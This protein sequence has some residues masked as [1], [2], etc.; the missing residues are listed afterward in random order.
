MSR[1]EYRIIWHMRNQ[2]KILKSQVKIQSID[3][4]SEMAQM[5]ELSGK[6][7]KQKL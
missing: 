5:L 2:K 1:V 4:N 7:I 3:I 6:Y